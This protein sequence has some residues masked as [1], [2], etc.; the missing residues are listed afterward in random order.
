V[1]RVTFLSGGSYSVLPQIISAAILCRKETQDLIRSNTLETA[2][3]TAFAR[4]LDK[5]V[6]IYFS[7][8]LQCV[9]DPR[10][11]TFTYGW[12]AKLAQKY[13]IDPKTKHLFN[14]TKRLYVCW[15]Y[16]NE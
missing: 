6:G 11:R 1:T 16:L 8:D 14:E 10:V 13:K 15:K 9:L 2:E 4:E 12:L 7:K 5:Q 3:G